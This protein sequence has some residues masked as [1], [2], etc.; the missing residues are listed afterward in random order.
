MADVLSTKVGKRSSAD[1]EDSPSASSRK[2]VKKEE[3][4]VAE[5]KYNPYLAHTYQ[6]GY[7]NG[8]NGF[9]GEAASQDSPFAGFKRRATS[10]KQA[11]SLEDSDSNPFTGRPHSQK[12]FQILETRRDLPVHK[13][14]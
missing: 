7:G 14:R 10:A 12:Y 13:Q 5:E 4:S 11:A 2:K 3:Q 6:N 9:D 1:A 8:A